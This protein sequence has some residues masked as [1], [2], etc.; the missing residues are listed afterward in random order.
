[1]RQLTEAGKRTVATSDRYSELS[2][3]MRLSLL[4]LSFETKAKV[5]LTRVREGRCSIKSRL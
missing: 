4:E 5:G 2:S 3:L 1:M